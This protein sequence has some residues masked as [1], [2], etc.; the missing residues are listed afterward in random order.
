M[1]SRERKEGGEGMSTRAQDDI[2]LY[3]TQMGYDPD[4]TYLR[5]EG[6]DIV[7]VETPES[8]QKLTVNEAEDIM[9]ITQD[10]SGRVIAVSDRGN[11]SGVKSWSMKEGEAV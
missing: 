1:L 7:T 10:G 5:Y 11:V 8:S 6:G 2:I 4:T 9:E 3:L